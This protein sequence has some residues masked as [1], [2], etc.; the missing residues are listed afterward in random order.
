MKLLS[1]ILLIF[2]LQSCTISK[3]K[4]R[5]VEGTFP[6][7]SQGLK[8]NPETPKDI[9]VLIIHGIGPQTEDYANPFIQKMAQKLGYTLNDTLTLDTMSF[10]NNRGKTFIHKYKIKGNWISFYSIFWSEITQPY[11]ERLKENHSEFKGNRAWLNNKI[12]KEVLNDNLIDFVLY[13][14]NTFKKEI[15][16]P[17]YET[18]NKI[19]EDNIKVERK[20]NLTKS[21]L[22]P[23]LDKKIYMISGSL[24]SKIL[25]DVISNY[26]VLPGEKIVLPE[27]QK[28]Y[29]DQLKSIFMLSNQLPLLS[30]SYASP[31]YESTNYVYQNYF[32]LCNFLNQ[33]SNSTINL[34]SFYDPNDI[35]GYNPIKND[36][37]CSLN[38]DCQECGSRINRSRIVLNNARN[39]A[40]VFSPI[41]KAHVEVWNNKKV[42][43]YIINGTNTSK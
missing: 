20:Y 31:D 32:G 38:R 35:L 4:L 3:Y 19:Y 12:K 29:K 30:L 36:P 25:L 18:L 6:G 26:E 24:G 42:L 13:T 8:T 14:S 34:V 15:K 40:D 37:D 43:Q 5:K 2:L 17:V 16:H 21:I 28:Y 27:I 39:I 11:R 33:P 10:E 7:I 1:F 41:K 9:K 23:Q 22:T